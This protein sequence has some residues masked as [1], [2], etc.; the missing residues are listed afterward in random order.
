ML[1]TVWKECMRDK[2]GQK[3][4]PQQCFLRTLK[5]TSLFSQV[6]VDWWESPGQE[7]DWGMTSCTIWTQ[8]IQRL[9]H[10]H[11]QVQVKSHIA[12]INIDR[13]KNVR[14]DILLSFKTGRSWFER[15]EQVWSEVCTLSSRSEVLHI[16]ND[17]I[18]L[19]TWLHERD[20]YTRIS[21]MP[22]R[23]ATRRYIFI[24]EV[25]VLEISRKND[26]QHVLLVRMNCKGK[27]VKF[28]TIHV[29][30]CPN[31]FHTY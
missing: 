28:T 27:L 12:Y 14:S 3:L 24:I 20:N 31:V 1:L 18:S 22:K 4:E 15:F 11:K 6:T 10:S 13:F 16:E 21:R 5:R 23:F 17:P 7:L 19:K 30:S 29:A 26:V 25:L 2:Y 9:L 8:Q